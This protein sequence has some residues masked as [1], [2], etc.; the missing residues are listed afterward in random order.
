MSKYSP[1][2][3]YLQSQAT[4][5]V[6]MSFSEVEVVLGSAL[7]NSAYRHRPWWANETK[8]HVH[9][10]AWL[11]AGYETAKVDMAGRKLVFRRTSSGNLPNLPPTAP[12]SG[13]SDTARSFEQE[14]L[15]KPRRNPLFGSM[16]GTFTIAPG[17]DLTSPIYS[18]EEWAKIEKEM[19]ADW[20]EIERGMQSPK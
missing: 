15:K 13:F 12:Q 6:P 17:Y 4:A 9:A 8:G 7:P 14:G 3:S 5:E 20:D 16:K 19:E 1:L 10:E 18:D 11:M 2:K